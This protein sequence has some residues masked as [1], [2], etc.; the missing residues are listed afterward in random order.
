MTSG[1]KS[2]HDWSY[3]RLNELVE[4]VVIIE[5]GTACFNTKPDD[6]EKGEFFNGSWSGPIETLHLNRSNT[7]SASDIP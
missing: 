7:N 6:K 5:A 1:S 2:F 4:E 3:R